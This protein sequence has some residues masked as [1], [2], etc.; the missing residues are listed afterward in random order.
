MMV[1]FRGG[2]FDSSKD[3]VKRAA[4]SPIKSVCWSMLE[5]GTRSSVS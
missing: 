5:R 3:K 1:L 2:V 4:R